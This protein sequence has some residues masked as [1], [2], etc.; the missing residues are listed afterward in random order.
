[1]SRFSGRWSRRLPLALVALVFAGGNLV[2]F[3]GYRSSTHDRRAALEARRPGPYQIQ[4]AIAALHDEAP[5][6]DDTDWAQIVELYRALLALDPSPVVELNLGAAV[7]MADGPAVGLAMIDGAAMGGA[8]EDY[9]YYH[10]AR[11]ELLRRLH[12]WSEAAE[13]Y[14]RAAALTTNRAEGT[15]LDRRLAD[16]EGSMAKAAGARGRPA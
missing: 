2:F 7:A 13:A 8:L 10:S 14:R 11:A 15:F 3:L 6:W 1:M 12:R 4:A 16:I 5:S 9:P